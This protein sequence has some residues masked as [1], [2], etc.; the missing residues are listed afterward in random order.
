MRMNKKKYIN[1]VIDLVMI[2]LMPLL[3]A[4]SL[5]GESLHEVIGTLIF[6]L[7]IVHHLLHGGWW[8]AIR[9]GK[10]TSYKIFLSILNVILLILMILQPVSGIVL[11]RHLFRFLH[12]TGLSA[13][14][15]SIHMALSYWSYVLMSLHLGLHI[16]AI[17]RGIRRGRES[18]RRVK[19]IIGIIALA[20]S[21]YGI[22]AFIHRGFPGY[23]FLQTRFAFFDTSE[24][25]IFFFADYLAIMILFAALGFWIEKS[26]KKKPKEIKDNEK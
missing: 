15:R 22:Y 10:Y 8:K 24:P 20:I 16:D 21:A 25:R 26:L 17:V 11:S 12:I 5:V 18:S 2:I 9:K 14:A 7:F 13:P 1:L 19:W 23:M 3:M 6:V 4:Y